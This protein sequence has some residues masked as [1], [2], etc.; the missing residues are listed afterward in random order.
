MNNKDT[1]YLAFTPEWFAKNQKILL[2]LFNLIYK[3]FPSLLFKSSDRNTF[4]GKE[5]IGVGNSY[6]TCNA[7]LQFFLKSDLIKTASENPNHNHRERRIYKIILRKMKQGKIK[8][9]KRLLPAKTSVFFTDW[10]Y[11][12]MLYEAFKPMWW[13][14][15]YWDEFFADRF[16][17]QFS[18]GFSTL[19]KTPVA[20]ANSPC[21][22][23]TRIVNTDSTI[24][25]IRVASGNSANSVN[26]SIE[27]LLYASDTTNQYKHLYRGIFNF[28]TSALG[29]SATISA[30]TLDWYFTAKT[31]TFSPAIAP[32]VDV[33][34]ATVSSPASVANSDFEGCGTTSQTGSPK[35]YAGITTSAN[36][37]FTFDATGRG[38]VNKTGISSFSARIANFD[39]GSS[40][41]TWSASPAVAG[42]Y[43]RAADFGSNKPT[44]T[45][46]Y[47]AETTYYVTMSATESSS[48]S[49]SKVNTFLR[50][51]SVSEAASSTMSNL[52]TFYR[53]LSSSVSGA[54]TFGIARPF[55]Q[56]L[57]A[58]ETSI[59]SLSTTNVIGQ[60][61][62]ATGSFTVSF[63]KINTFARSLSAAITGSATLSKINSFYRTLSATVGSSATIDKGFVFTTIL[64]ATATGIATL[65][66]IIIYCRTLSVQVIGITARIKTIMNGIT[67]GIWAKTVKVADA[68]SKT[69]RTNDSWS[70]T[71]KVADAWAKTAKT[72][73]SWNKT[74]RAKDDW[75]KTERDL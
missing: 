54:S 24:A 49:L 2:V 53:S 63:S 45:V 72:N 50:A 30:T 25:N 68:W 47:T 67:A 23:S 29:A 31:D 1:H 16:A 51:L 18:F 19:A 36:N 61:L 43:I 38:N 48:I 64:S 20:G 66:R 5:I 42:F 56:A 9:E 59:A 6:A 32:T 60:I 71:A 44:L 65:S 34:L 58:I 3:I 14:M 17:P 73:D 41:P 13:T 4:K 40:T 57:S 11:S 46:T 21:D 7:G 26:N 28:D 12:E 33:F 62:S 55:S 75:N 69:A 39:A 74:A 70:K 10:N 52:K 27:I 37:T 15:H 35:T 22:G 8:E